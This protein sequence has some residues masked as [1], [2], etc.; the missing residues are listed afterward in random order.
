MP[1]QDH[2][3]SYL[4]AIRKA[5]DSE[6]SVS[7]FFSKI[8]CY[9]QETADVENAL[10]NCAVLMRDLGRGDECVQYIKNRLLY[11]IDKYSFGCAEENKKNEKWGIKAA[12]ALA[13]LKSA[14][15]A[16]GI[17]FFLKGGVLLGC[18]R[19][20]KILEHDYDIDVGVDERFD[21]NSIESALFGAG[22]FYQREND[23]DRT[24]Y[25]THENGVHVDVFI[26]YLEQGCY[27]NRGMYLT[28]RNKPFR[29]VERNFLEDTYL[30][31]D[32][33]DTYL[34][35]TYGDWRSPAPHYNTYTD[36]L[37]TEVND[38]VWMSFYFLSKIA[39]CYKM[40][41]TV[42]MNKILRAYLALTND[43]SLF[44]AIQAKLGGRVD[45]GVGR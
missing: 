23:N 2:S 13:D 5:V 18:V 31:P 24:I 36:N 4:K 3:F 11:V 38:Q 1:F 22:K 10:F 6:E 39:V 43:F 7:W 27:K 16:G 42:S 12:V 45:L 20:G 17:E 15:D 19:E 25:I 34:S 9:K 28:W 21:R 41:R 40:G 29:L 30:I 37:N 35:E 26:H 32:D 8:M 33:F 14:M 44:D